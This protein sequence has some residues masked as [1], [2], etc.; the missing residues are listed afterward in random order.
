MGK[1]QISDFNAIDVVKY[2]LETF[3]NNCSKLIWLASSSDITPLVQGLT[4]TILVLIYFRWAALMTQSVQTNYL[5]MFGAILQLHFG[6]HHTR[7]FYNQ[8]YDKKILRSFDNFSYGFLLAKLLKIQGTLNILTA[9]ICWSLK[10]VAIN[11]Q[12]SEKS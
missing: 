2:Y 7:Y 1:S 6:R 4:E 12:I 10:P 5:N 11:C 8:Y 3:F 9:Y